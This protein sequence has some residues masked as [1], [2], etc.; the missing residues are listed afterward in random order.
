MRR[1]GGF[2]LLEM[3]VATA[4]FLMG[5]V[6]IY[7][8]FSG[9]TTTTAA[10]TMEVDLNSQNK[11]A[12]TAAYMELQATSL[13]NHDINEDGTEEAVFVVEAGVG[14][15]P[16]TKPRL[17]SRTVGTPSQAGGVQWK[18][19]E[20]KEQ[21]R[22]KTIVANSRI[23]FRKVVGYRF[24]AAAGSIE[25]EWSSEIVYEVNAGR[26][27]VR[28]IEGGGGPPKVVAHYVDA[29]DVE[30]KVDGTVVVTLVSARKSPDGHG[31]RRYAN[32]VTVHPKN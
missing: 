27:L 28:R 9:V 32:A 25:P 11:K 24:N 17:V 26:Q 7:S 5:A 2:T 12:L 20:G 18:L 21:A 8:T 19:G 16:L 15:T 14:P 29:F 3:V 10:V 1:D 13:S 22:E 23:R 6:F 31:F 30:T 4:I